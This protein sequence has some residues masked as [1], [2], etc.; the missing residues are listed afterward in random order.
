MGIRTPVGTSSEVKCAC[1]LG[2]HMEVRHVLSGALPGKGKV[3]VA[4]SLEP[5][6]KNR[7]QDQNGPE[8]ALS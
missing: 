3:P 4:T 2:G 1:R 5:G 6:R 8:C 7:E